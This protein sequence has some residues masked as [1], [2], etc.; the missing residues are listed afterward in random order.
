M[1]QLVVWLRV[2]TGDARPEPED[3]VDCCRVRSKMR[4]G[5][6]TDAVMS[7]NATRSP[8]ARERSNET[9]DLEAPLPLI[10]IGPGCADSCT[11]LRSM[12]ACSVDVGWPARR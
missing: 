8:A 7:L 4:P 9:I 5:S 6:G 12:Y 2:M 3:T 11:R 1:A 10:V